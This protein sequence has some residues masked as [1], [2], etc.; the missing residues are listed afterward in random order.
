MREKMT[1]DWEYV[2]FMLQLARSNPLPPGPSGK[3]L[4][5]SRSIPGI[6]DPPAADPQAKA[7]GPGFQAIQVFTHF[8]IDAVLRKKDKANFLEWIRLLRELY[9]ANLPAAAWFLNTITTD[10]VILRASL[11]SARHCVSVT[12]TMTVRGSVSEPVP[13]RVIC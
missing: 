6:R 3:F 2:N 9:I 5:V 12:V 11:F 8:L 10:K 1:S 7:E 13:G 4:E